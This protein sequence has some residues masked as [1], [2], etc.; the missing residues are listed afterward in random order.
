MHRAIRWFVDETAPF[1][2]A[3]ARQVGGRRVPDLRRLIAE[4]SGQEGNL[5]AHLGAVIGKGIPGSRIAVEVLCGSARVRLFL[6][7][8]SIVAAA[9]GGGG[10]I[11][12]GMGYR[13]D[14]IQTPCVCIFNF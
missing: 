5:A 11:V 13:V 7:L 8:V 12:A 6:L 3:V 10:T 9:G 4:T 14:D 2:V 1:E